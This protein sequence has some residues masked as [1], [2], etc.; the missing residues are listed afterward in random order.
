MVDVNQ[1]RFK[2]HQIPG[3]IRELTQV[4]FHKGSHGLPNLCLK[5]AVY[6]SYPEEVASPRTS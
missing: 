6:R 4:A 1:P 2:P 5:D 3:S